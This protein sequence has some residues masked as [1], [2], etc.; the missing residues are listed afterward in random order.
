MKRLLAVCGIGIAILG[1]GGT[2][3][4]ASTIQIVD[5][6]D[7]WTLT[8]EDGCTTDCDVSLSVLYDSSVRTG[9]E[10]L[11]VQWGLDGAT[12]SNENLVS[13]SNGTWTYGA[14]IVNDGGC[15]G[16]NLQDACFDTTG[17]PVIVADGLY[18]W[19]F[20]ADFSDS[21]FTAGLI[22]AAY[23]SDPDGS[24]P[25]GKLF[26]PGSCALGQIC[27]GEGEGSQG[28]EPA[29]LLLFGMGLSAAGVRMRRARK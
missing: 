21:T 22:R 2:R 9:S 10:L 6:T 3:A 15:G 23:D 18:T 1:F 26:S 19:T 12:V 13:A 11:A 4:Y 29:S 5:G 8:V 20:T 16:G 27:G 7:L 25:L 24:G 17:T 14:G 28:P